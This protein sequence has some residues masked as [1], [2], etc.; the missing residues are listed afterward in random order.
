MADEGY[1]V[2]E[3][4]ITGESLVKNLLSNHDS[5]YNIKIIDDETHENYYFDR[6]INDKTN[7]KYYWNNIDRSKKYHV[8]VTEYSEYNGIVWD[9]FKLLYHIKEIK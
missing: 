2:F 8:R 5:N 4:D 6:L 1:L 7:K 9:Y 3:R